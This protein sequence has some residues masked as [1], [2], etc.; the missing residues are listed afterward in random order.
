MATT[1]PVV[2]YDLELDVR[3]AE[4]MAERLV[5]YIYE[6]ELYGPMPGSL[7]KLT[8][9]GLLMRLHRLSII[10][11]ILKPEQREAV[12]RA[13]AQLEKV[14][15]QWPVAYEGK[16]LQ[17]LKARFTSMEQMISEC[18]ES[19]RVCAEIYPSGI[20]KRVITEVL[21]DEA[22]S[23]AIMTS[24]ARAILIRI[25]TRIRQVV[26]PNGEFLWDPRLEPAYSRDKF[27][28]LY[29]KFAV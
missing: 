2:S 12:K 5:P 24:E 20:E 8:V 14:R 29:V 26:K 10:A 23:L 16:L 1:H 4:A 25:D 3:A 9:G 17:E 22:E 11:D 19:G 18:A 15:K 21:K 7:P 6:A 28:F 13:R 27:W